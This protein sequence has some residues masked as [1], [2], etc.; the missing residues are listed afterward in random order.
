LIKNSYVWLGSTALN[1][2]EPIWTESN[3]IEPN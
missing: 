2:T 3:W 1:L